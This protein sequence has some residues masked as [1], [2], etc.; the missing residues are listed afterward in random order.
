MLSLREA[1]TRA[2]DQLSANPLLSATALADA[3]LLLMHTL[4]IERSTLIAHP[5]RLMDR[6]QQRVYQRLIERRLSFEPV[7]YITGVQEFYGLQFRVTPAVLIPRPETELLVEAVL[8]RLPADR[9]LRIVDVGTGSGAIAI[10]LAVHLPLAYVTAIDLSLPALSI[11]QQNVASHHCGDRIR[12]VESDLLL[13]LEDEQPF[14]AIVSNPPYV[15]EEDAPTLHP[16]V[17]DHEPASALF[18]GA[19][20][21]DIY[22]R[23]IPQAERLLKPG[24]LLALEFGYG[25]ADSI[26]TLLETWNGTTL[27]DDL[28]AIPRIALATRAPGATYK[29]A[30]QS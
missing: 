24:G 22:R 27:L 1:L 3:A 30:Y 14:D 26:R 23:L 18:A 12:V 28:Q 25:Q 13:A 19:S 4:G 11:A 6:E 20:G 9:S 5:E 2:T 8:A 10:A 29:P 7:Q 21:L 15:A 17:R 16:Q